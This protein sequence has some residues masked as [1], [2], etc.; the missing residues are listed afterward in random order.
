MPEL[1]S[2]ND[3]W[4]IGLNTSIF[5]YHYYTADSSR[6]RNYAENILLDPATQALIPDSTR[7][8]RNGFNL[9]S[10]S[11]YRTWG[12]TVQI[13]LGRADLDKKRMV[14]SYP[15]IHLEGLSTR[16]TTTTKK[17]P[18]RADTLVYNAGYANRPFTGIA[19]PVNTV[20]VTNRTKAYF[21]VG[22]TTY[23]SIPKKFDF[24]GQAIFGVSTNNPVYKVASEELPPNGRRTIVT[25]TYGPKAFY[26]FKTRIT[27]KYTKLNGTAGVEVRGNLGE[28]DPFIAAYLGIQLTLDTFF[29]K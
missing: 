12:Y 14:R 10:K 18:I 11:D 24:Y 19:R 7:F 15:T 9:E 22:Y 2:V 4:T 20:E 28:T 1:W 29:K 26:L 21:G 16:T 13:L 17:I 3:K 5:H 25:T 8:V 23:V 27:E 6:G